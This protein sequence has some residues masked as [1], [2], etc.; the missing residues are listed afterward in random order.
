MD[1]RLYYLGFSVFPGIG[2]VIFEKLRTHFGSAKAAWN[3]SGEEL[4]RVGL[5]R[6]LVNNFEHFKKEFSHKKYSA[7]LREKSIRFVVKTDKN[8]PSSLM[9]IRNPPIGLYQKGSG[10][11][12]HNSIAIVG[13][14]RVSSYGRDV[15]EMIATDLARVGFVIVSGLAVGVDTVAHTAAIKN[16]GQTI[17]VLGCGVDCCSP[18]E[19]APLYNSIVGGGGCVVS[20]LPLGHPP[21]KGSFPSRN[22][23]IAGLSLGVVVT[24]GAEDSGALITADYALA[25]GRKVFAVPG[26]ITSPLSKGPIKLIQKGAKLVTSAEDIMLELGIMNQ[27]SGAKKRMIKGETKEEQKILELLEQEP[28]HFDEIVKRSKL[29]SSQIGSLLSLMEIKGMVKSNGSLFTIAS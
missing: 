14:R 7:T 11:L 1:E 8:Y 6:K 22:R 15:T 27:E 3:A 19:N 24:E 20:E 16:N 12:T 4:Y 2:P 25:F 28:L 29:S 21:T 17:A 23:I 10:E 9:Q 18:R 26:P 5:N 13:T